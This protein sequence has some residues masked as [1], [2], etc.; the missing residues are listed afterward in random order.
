MHD[1]DLLA[2]SEGLSSAPRLARN[3]AP[4]ELA[5]ELPAAV[6]AK[7]LG[8]RVKRAVAWN[9]EAGN[10]HPRYAAAVARRPPGRA[11]GKRSDGQ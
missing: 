8:Y 7:L 10:T 4:T 6:I 5:S 1:G 9:I 11:R 2:A 3:T